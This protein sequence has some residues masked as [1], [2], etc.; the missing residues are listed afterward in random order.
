M[1]PHHYKA[2]VIE[3]STPRVFSYHLSELPNR[4][5]SESEVLVRVHYSSLNY[6]DILS[7]QGN[8]AV[9][10]RF[11]H[12]PGLDAGGVVERSNSS[13]FK[14][15]DKVAV[16][17][18][19]MGMNHSGGLAEYIT[20]PEQWL[21]EVPDQISLMQVMVFGT[22]GYTSTL[23][24][25]EIIKHTPPG[26]SVLVTGASGGVG[27]I[28]AILL[29]KLGFKVTASVSREQGE[30]FVK[31][32]GIKD[33]IKTN[34]LLGKG[35]HNLLPQKWD[36]IVDV[37]GGEVLS[38][39]LKQVKEEG[40]VIATGLAAG[41]HFSSTVLPFILR[42]ITLK[43]INAEGSSTEKKSD[44][45]HKLASEWN[46]DELSTVYRL[47]Q[48]KDVCEAIRAYETHQIFGRVVVNME[49][50]YYE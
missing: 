22:A 26:G 3:K 5:L 39:L 50:N 25:E 24:V 44:F 47:V 16:F 37:A 18:S 46:C 48:F 4:E 33:V 29:N 10:R 43:G 21:V 40:L 34:S 20:V 11:P 27:S 13:K 12:T 23:A 38:A 2:L 35:S 1:K 28:S 41:T 15:G 45:L 30:A 42:G 9:T 31:S 8:P 17:C 7:C 49:G 6:K 19:P 32:F 14:A 36:A